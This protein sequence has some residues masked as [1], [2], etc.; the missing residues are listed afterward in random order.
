MMNKLLAAVTLFAF[1]VAAGG[2]ASAQNRY[3]NKSLGVSVAKPE[4]WGF[5]TD[6]QNRDNLASTHMA[7]FQ[8]VVVERSRAPIFAITKYP[9]PHDDLNPSVKIRV[10]PAGNLTEEGLVAALTAIQRS[11]AD[12]VADDSVSSAVEIA[13]IDGFPA[14]RGDIDFT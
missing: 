9:V 2:N 13:E 11:I 4:S 10:R 1:V 6:Q 3:E 7:E 14:A 8:K 12:K 5:E